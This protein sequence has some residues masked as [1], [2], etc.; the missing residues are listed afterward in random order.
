MKHIT[1][2]ITN[3]LSKTIGSE[4]ID[5]TQLWDVADRINQFKS[6]I[7]KAPYPFMDFELIRSQLNDVYKKAEV[8]RTLKIKNL[9]LLG[10]GGSSLGTETIFN[11]LLD[12]LHNIDEDARG[13]R[14]R[15]FIL[16]N[17]DPNRIKRVAEL[18]KNEK[19]ETL[20]VVI[21][22]SGE[23]PE[24]MSQFMVF[25]D[26]MK[27]SKRYKERVMVITDKSKGM[28]REIVKKEGYPSLPVPEGIGGRFSVLTPVGMFPSCVM[29]LDIEEIINGA[30]AMREHIE[31]ASYRKNLA[32]ILASIL[33]LM[34]RNGKH[35]HV[36]MPYC[37]RLNAFA[38]WFRQLEAES[39]G[40][41]GMGPTPLKSIGVT[42]QHSQ[43]QLY[44]D[45]PKDKCITFIYCANDKQPIPDSIPYIDELKYLAGKDIEELFQAEFLGT[46]RS[47]TEAKTP[48]IT[49]TLD[50]IS[51]FI[52]GA[53]FF[54]YE[55]VIALMGYM[56]GV[57]AFDQP[58][59]ELGKTYTKALMGKKGLEE[60]RKVIEQELSKKRT[61]IEF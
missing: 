50:E 4:G 58:A 1:L 23:T 60:K 44:I 12:P 43:L 57:N 42:D 51:P 31:R 25:K 39:L 49:I 16:D 18:V 34:D 55:M 24:T 20:L 33:Y 28:L 21:S 59:V 17:I 53:L 9:I 14:P 11:A 48:N 26:I 5:R 36:I 3:V 47:L 22:K 27:N 30:H 52:I 32:V 35:M 54:L 13:K 15:Y 8:F 41:K 40:K 29:G 46:R 2:D 37:E 6:S 10:I 7:F 19:D 45:G 61:T 38:D 56:Y